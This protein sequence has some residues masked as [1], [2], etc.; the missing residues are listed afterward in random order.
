MVNP[1]TM[2]PLACKGQPHDCVADSLAFTGLWS[3][4]ET[5]L[6]LNAAVDYFVD[7]DSSFTAL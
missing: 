2:I 4:L 3:D 1:A 6:I 7:G 5:T